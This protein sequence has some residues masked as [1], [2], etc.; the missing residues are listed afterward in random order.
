MQYFPIHP[1]NPQIRILQKVVSV[2]KDDNGICVY[3]TDTVYGMGVAASNPK[4]VDKIGDVLKKDKK[5]L[6]S[7][8]CCDFSQI[9]LYARLSTSAFKLLKRYL[10]GPYTFLLPATGFVPKKVCPKRRVVGI[11]FPQ[12]PTVIELVRLLGEPLANT[13]IHLPGNLRGDPVAVK[14]AM[15]NDVDIMLDAGILSEPVG[16]TIIDLTTDDPVLVRPG[17]GIWKE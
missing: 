13:S 9:S 1:D 11:R 14:A 8:I 3:P 5:R 4:A 10:P 6:L 16:S 15:L 12:S 7:Y 17:K 2:L